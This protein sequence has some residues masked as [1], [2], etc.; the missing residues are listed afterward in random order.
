[1][2]YFYIYTCL[3]YVSISSNL[4]PLLTNR[5][6]S[7]FGTT[8]WIWKSNSFNSMDS[9]EYRYAVNLAKTFPM[10][11]QS[12]FVRW[13][14]DSLSRYHKTSVITRNLHVRWKNSVEWLALLWDMKACVVF[15]TT[16]S[17]KLWKELKN[18]WI[19]KEEEPGFVI[20]S[21]LIIFV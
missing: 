16:I 15:I 11:N 19:K 13:M 4:I 9:L 14:M 3:C 5:I 2:P 7:W 17:N 12:I 21:S 20:W 10:S 6:V 1:M 8:N 18:L